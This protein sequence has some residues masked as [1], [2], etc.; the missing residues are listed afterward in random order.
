MI[1]RS[2][3]IAAAAAAALLA[4][5]GKSVPTEKGDEICFAAQSTDSSVSEQAASEQAATTRAVK[6]TDDNITG[7]PFGIYGAYS[8][9]NG[10]A[11]ATNVF[12]HASAVKVEFT[13]VEGETDWFYSQASSEGKKYYWKRNMYYRFRAY[14]PYDADINTGGSS[15]DRISI[16]YRTADD[17]S[18]LLVA[19][20]TRHPAEEGYGR[21]DMNFQH[22]LSALRFRIAFD[23]SYTPADEVDTLT[24]FCVKGME[25]AGNMVYS[26]SGD[27]LTPEIRW[28]GDAF[29][30]ET[31]FFASSTQR[32][33]GVKGYTPAG[34]S[35]VTPVDVYGT[36]S[37]DNIVFAIP[38]TCSDSEHTGT[39]VHFTTKLGGHADHSVKLPQQEW[40]PGKI[41]TYN[42]LIKKAS[43][44]I[45]VTISE[46]K[47]VQSTV[48]IYL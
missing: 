6:T 15:A 39:Y 46:W 13:T 11:V 14:H 16:N 33:F 34:G 43:V 38:Q 5:C 4:G 21:V 10:A 22:A 27:Y 30:G 47:E 19:F 36:G 20:A 37:G 32:I 24:H 17:S 25:V 42:L 23:S 2:Y 8:S 1:K 7:A 31:E 41:Y 44:D 29:D 45:V 26:H 18:D 3:I 35:A 28:I 9:S 12:D 48:N 40:E